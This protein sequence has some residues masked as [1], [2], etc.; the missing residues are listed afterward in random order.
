VPGM[1]ATVLVLLVITPLSWFVV[2]AL[3]SHSWMTPG[4]LDM[5]LPTAIHG[6]KL[7]GVIDRLRSLMSWPAQVGV[8]AALAIALWRGDRVRLWLFAAV[9]VWCAV[10]VG[11]ALHGFSAVARYLVEPAAVLFVLLGATAGELLCHLRLPALRP[12]RLPALR[13]SRGL[14]AGL[15]GPA[16]VVAGILALL[17]GASVA[18]RADRALIAH[19][20]RDA[21]ALRRLAR[22]IA[23]DGGR[24]AV[25]ACGQPVSYL[26]YQSTLAWE[27][28]MNVGQVGFH[29]GRAIDSGNPIVFFKPHDF[30]WIV[31]AD[32]E[33]RTLRVRC[34][35]LDRQTSFG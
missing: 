5:N 35:R 12:G 9:A 34:A 33:P 26:G 22:V 7:I 1:R 21:L 25:L 32:N 18:A 8:A 3:T 29:P 24:A 13:P 19:E 14:L 4:K 17:P 2:P 27:L 10:E 28:G 20:R 16:V 31:R 30:G 11:F 15:A 23:A 6:N